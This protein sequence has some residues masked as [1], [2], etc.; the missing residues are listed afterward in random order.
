MEFDK[1]KCDEKIPRSQIMEREGGGGRTFSYVS[2]YYVIK[3]LNE[4]FGNGGW[5]YD[6]I[7]MEKVHTESTSKGHSVHYLAQVRLAVGV[8]GAVYQEV[9]Y[10]DGSDKYNIGKAYEL[11]AKE[12]VT[13]AL[14]RAAKNLG[15]S[16][17]LCL[18]SKDQENVDDGPQQTHQA[19]GHGKAAKNQPK[20]GTASAGGS[21]KESSKGV[22]NANGSSDAAQKTP[23]AAK[24]ARAAL[25]ELI[26]STAS[27]VIAR[28]KATKD[29]LK[30]LLNEQ[31]SVDSPKDL[32]DDKANE[33]LTQL[34]GMVL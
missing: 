11:A 21:A 1:S 30:K 26:Q 23:D 13:D 15:M 19:A 3:R 27:V 22:A 34:K 29:D 20:D 9:G 6:I 2:G 4:V 8:L 12:A 25:N 28:K 16:F 7:A 5:S 33:F 31:F 32:A 18:Y 17:G 10:G 24:A 14:K